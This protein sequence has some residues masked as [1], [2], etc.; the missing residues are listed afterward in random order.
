MTREEQNDRYRTNIPPALLT[1]LNEY[2]LTGRPVGNCLHGFLTNDLSMAIAHADP[3]T[4]RAIK[5][6]HQYIHHRL[7]TMCHGNRAKY[8][9]YPLWIDEALQRQL[10]HELVW[11]GDVPEHHQH[12]LE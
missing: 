6:I 1:S 8:A 12:L 2:V 7:P 3:D 4:V 11:P 10:I 9:D 5:S